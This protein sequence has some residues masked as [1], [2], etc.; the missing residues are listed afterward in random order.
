MALLS[1]ESCRRVL[2]APRTWAGRLWLG[3][4]LSRVPLI[5]MRGGAV[6]CRVLHRLHD[7]SLG[8]TALPP[9]PRPGPGS[10][11]CQCLLSW[12]TGWRQ[13]ADWYDASIL[14]LDLSFKGENVMQPSSVWTGQGWQMAVGTGEGTVRRYR[15]R[16]PWSG[17]HLLEEGGLPGGEFADAG[18]WVIFEI[19]KSSRRG[20]SQRC[21]PLRS[22]LPKPCPHSHLGWGRQ[23]GVLGFP[24]LGA[25]LPSS[26]H[27]WALGSP[28]QPCYILA[29]GTHPL[30]VRMEVW[31]GRT[32]CR[33][34]VLCPRR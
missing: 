23:V 34:A 13:G 25:S 16:S 33:T 9:H 32:Y 5:S 22:C 18:I 8:D 14:N 3:L 12:P 26:A 28:S 20:T 24:G 6:V 30:Q 1:C 2:S 31:T 11:S 17:R 21:T 15:W 10:Q 7:L 29:S 19:L 27:S 4:W